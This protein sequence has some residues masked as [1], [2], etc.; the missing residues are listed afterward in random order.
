[1]P[2]KCLKI[3]KGKQWSGLLFQKTMSVES[4]VRS[5]GPGG[6]NV[7]KVATCVALLHKPTG[8]II[9]CQEF[10]T[11]FLNRQ[12]AWEML[13]E[14]LQERQEQERLFRQAK[15]E[16]IR[17]QNRKRSLSAKERMLENKKKNTFKKQNRKKLKSW[18]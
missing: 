11:Q 9:K 15:R 13:R 16:K 5:S 6:Q 3:S 14:A 12:Q 2:L 1:M 7:N 10:R 4:F 18:E 8:I 17:R